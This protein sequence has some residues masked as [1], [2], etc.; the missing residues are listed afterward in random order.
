MSM[1]C[2]RII[3]SYYF[4]F[5]N[6]YE[7]MKYERAMCRPVYLFVTETRVDRNKNICCQKC[8]TL[9]LWNDGSTRT[10]DTYPWINSIHHHVV[11]T[12]QHWR[13]GNLPVNLLLQIAERNL[14]PYVKAPVMMVKVENPPL[15]AGV[16]DAIFICPMELCGETFPKGIDL[17]RHQMAKSRFQNSRCEVCM[18]GFAS[19]FAV[20]RHIKAIHENIKYKCLE[21]GNMYGRLYIYREHR[22]KEHGII[23]WRC[24]FVDLG[25]FEVAGVY[26]VFPHGLIKGIGEKTRF[27]KMKRRYNDVLLW[28]QCFWSVSFNYACCTSFVVFAVHAKWSLRDNTRKKI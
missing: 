26:L 1:T 6:V 20:K 25:H 18:K 28:V 5:E 27:V 15:L 23:E 7:C 12:L 2:I 17:L 21:C 22:R 10:R 16:V 8:V 24:K 4:Q 19:D 3:D 13:S 9:L 11:D 14:D